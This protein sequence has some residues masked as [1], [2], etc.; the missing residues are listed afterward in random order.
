MIWGRSTVP[1]RVRPITR[2]APRPS[3]CRSQICSPG[4]LQGRASLPVLAGLD[5]EVAPGDCLALA[6]PSGFGKG[7][8]LKLIHGRY[9]PLAGRILI[10]HEGGVLDL[11]RAPP[12][13]LLEVRRR[14]L[15]YVSQ[16][17]RVL[18]RVVAL[19]VV[20]ELVIAQGVAREARARAG[21][22]LARLS[23]PQR[24]WSLPPAT[25]SGG[26]QQRVNLARTFA[27]DYRGDAPRRTHGLARCRQPCGGDRTDRAC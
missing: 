20:A 8:V 17:L 7:A 24:L 16:F 14:T 19:D 5:L 6:G 27:P 12:Q 22:L 21:G 25:F 26:E 1:H 3:S 23:V 4:N 18:P 13:L 10:H 15:G 2:T 9:L 11:A